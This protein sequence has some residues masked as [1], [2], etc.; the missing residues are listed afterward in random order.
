MPFK[1]TTIP[2]RGK[3]ILEV[4]SPVVIARFFHIIDRMGLVAQSNEPVLA[5]RG[6]AWKWWVCGL[7]LL[8]TM[9][10]YMDRLTINST[11]DRILEELHL[12]EWHY[13]VLEFAFGIAFALGS[14]GTGWLVD[15][16]NVRWMYPA[17]VLGWSA[18]GFATGFADEFEQL[19]LCR[20]ML[21]MFEGGNWT[22]A[23]R[24]TQRILS[25]DKRTT[26]NSILQS[27]AA[28]GAVLTPLIVLALVDGPGTWRYPFFV[29]GAAGCSWTIFWLLSVSTRDL[30]L[31]FSRDAESAERS[32]HDATALRSASRLSDG[33]SL[34]HI[35]RQRRFVVLLVLVIAINLT[36]HFFR[37]W[38]PLYLK[39][40]RG[41]EEGHVLQFTSFY[42]IAAD[43]GSLSAGFA[44]L[45]LVRRG[46]TVH[47][48]R[49]IVYG[50][51]ALLTT[52]SVV[53]ALIPT[54]LML[55]ALLL[56]LAFAALALFPPYY[57]FSQEL[58]T[59]HQGKLTGILG[60][61]TWMASAVMH[62]TVGQWI[63][64]TKEYAP[65]VA[66]AGLF[67]LLGL[68]ALLWL[69]RDA[70]RPTEPDA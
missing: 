3:H 15:R 37:A 65:A 34:W 17:V 54:G 70:K 62:L 13:G 33:P 25:A 42:Y 66:I 30:A 48:S 36:W 14:L 18:A 39:R 2:V 53:I 46:V 19:V 31:P 58:T 12:T 24:T 32:A 21:G 59:Q 8:A 45:G 26:G 68:V 28:L 44:A 57:S 49:V 47:R 6:A 56:V 61:S 1:T 9:I 69:W 51:A 7:L 20:F 5:S 35:C 22:C 16:Y 10:N 23:L 38:M 4:A 11:A 40:Y 64:E 43:I 55:L 29:I 41:Y 63:K 50:V 52:L 60:F 27:G 67:P